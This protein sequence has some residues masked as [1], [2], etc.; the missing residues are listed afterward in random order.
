MIIGDYNEKKAELRKEL[1]KKRNNLSVNEINQFSELISDKIIGNL[2]FQKANNILAYISFRN[3]VDVSKIIEK[4][5]NLNKQ[6]LIP[7][8]NLTKKNIQPY[9]I[10]SWG[11]LQIGNY[12]LLEPIIDNKETFPI[13]DVEVVLVPGVAFDKNGYRLGYG[14]GFY[15]RFFATCQTTLYKIGVAYDFQVIDE[16]PV[17]DHD[18]IVNEIITEKQII[19]IG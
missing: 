13:A 18:C 11:E 7:K 1:I 3:E 4:A 8:T 14:G 10:N 16:L 9:E 17:L 19:I 6:V 5:W 15:D 12:Q 2:Y